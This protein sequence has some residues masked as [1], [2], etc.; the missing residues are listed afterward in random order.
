[1]YIPHKLP[2][3]AAY[4]VLPAHYL[5]H[6][7]AS[8]PQHATLHKAMCEGAKAI[9]NLHR[10]VFFENNSRKSVHINLSIDP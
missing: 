8:P 5:K 2:Y 4:D 9:F 3:A 7:I 10:A 6:E 1:M